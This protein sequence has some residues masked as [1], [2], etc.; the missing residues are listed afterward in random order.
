MF[1]GTDKGNNNTIRN[2]TGE[3]KKIEPDYREGVRTQLERMKELCKERNNLYEMQ[4]DL[5]GQKW[6]IGKSLER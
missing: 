2:L 1:V 4:N 6:K 5:K 3:Y